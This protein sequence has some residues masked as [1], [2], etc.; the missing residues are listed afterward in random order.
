MSNFVKEL[1]AV[2]G[3]YIFPGTFSPCVQRCISNN[4]RSL[5]PTNSVRRALHFLP[6][7]PDAYRSQ[8]RVS[9]APCIACYKREKF[10]CR[11]LY[12]LLVWKLFCFRS[13]YTRFI[14]KAVNGTV[15]S[16]GPMVIICI[17]KCN[18]KTLYVIPTEC[19][20]VFCMDLRTNSEYSSTQ[21]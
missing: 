20:S 4:K 5:C 19:T 18:I 17:T 2:V 21:I 12:S 11:I 9:D 7:I 14:Y 8:E 10:L 13:K 15:T 6:D 16:Y 3:D 1:V